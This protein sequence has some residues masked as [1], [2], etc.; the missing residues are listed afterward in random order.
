[1]EI[2]LQRI[3][4]PSLRHKH[5]ARKLTDS[6]QIWVLE[7]ISWR[8]VTGILTIQEIGDLAEAVSGEGERMDS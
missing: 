3:L 2:A 7:K 4:I 8:R 1:M 6:L 5:N